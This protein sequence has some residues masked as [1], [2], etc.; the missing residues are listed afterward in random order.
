MGEVD[1]FSERAKFNFLKTK[2][3]SEFHGI[4]L[5]LLKS[6]QVISRFNG[7]YDEMKKSS[8]LM[9]H[10][11]AVLC[12]A[13]TNI[14]NPTFHMVSAITNSSAIFEPSLRANKVFQQILSAN[15]G[16][17]NAKSSVLAEFILTRFPNAVLLVNCIV[18]I[19]KN[20]H[21][22]SQGNQLYF[23]FYKDLASFR[24]IQKILPDTG[25][26]DSLILFYQG[27]KE[28]PRERENPHFWLQYAIARLSV[29]DKDNL[30]NAQRHLSHALQLARAK[31]GYWTD[32]IET[33]YA[34]YYLE[35]ATRSFDLEEINNAM[36]EFSL[37]IGKI[38]MVHKRDKYR[39]ELY[40]PI[41]LVK[42]FYTT[43]RNNLNPH[44]HLEIM[45]KCKEL[46]AICKKDAAKFEDDIQFRRAKD[47]VD[48]VLREINLFL[49]IKDNEA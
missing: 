19:A 39:K 10:I 21:E 23:K 48:W 28:I 42:R 35:N 41:A 46:Q 38:L 3:N 29:P 15:D 9:D 44:H 49:H 25:K 26:R 11:V 36:E 12:L 37:G 30:D 18:Q 24:Y 22:K 13:I 47:N 8:V 2:A 33:Q 40:R 7:F 14:S 43:H 32:D 5:G 6:P 20:A 4:L 27:L 34:R 16:K 45:G 1:L 31:P 17:L